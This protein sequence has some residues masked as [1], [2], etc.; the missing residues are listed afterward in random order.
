MRTI[1]LAT[2]LLCATH[3]ICAA[4]AKID[5]QGFS[6]YVDAA[7]AWVAPPPPVVAVAIK[8]HGWHYVLNDSQMQ[9]GATYSENTHI[10]RQ[11]NDTAGLQ[12]GARFEA[13]FD[14]AYQRLTFHDISVLRGD[15][16]IDVL[17]RE[18]ISLLR[19]E[20]GLERS[21]YDGKVTAS[22]VVPGA[23]VG[24]RLSYRYTVTGSNP[25]F[26]NKFVYWYPTRLSNAATDQLRFRFVYPAERQLKFSVPSGAQRTDQLIDTATRE[27]TISRRGSEKLEVDASSDPSVYLQDLLQVSEYDSW[28]DVS[29]WGSQLFTYV[30]GSD[31]EVVKLAA[32]LRTQSKHDAAS[33]TAA[34]IDF[35][36]R[37]VRYFGIFFADSSHRPNAPGLVLSRRFGDC[38]DKALL[39]IALLRELGV[40]ASPV[41]VSQFYRGAVTK[42]MPSPYAFDHVIVAAKVDGVLYWIDPTRLFGAGSLANRQAWAFRQG[43]PLDTA[44]ALAVAP[45]RPEGDLDLEATDRFTVGNL[46]EPARLR[47]EVRY[48]GEAAERVASMMTSPQRA[49]VEGVIFEFVDRLFQGR[50]EAGPVQYERNET[51]GDVLLAREYAIPNLFEIN[52]QL[53]LV[54]D[55]APWTIMGELRTNP[56]QKTDY[57]LGAQRRSR[58]RLQ[59]D[60]ADK[61]F[62]EAAKS[63]A[64]T[65]DAHFRL[66]SELTTTSTSIAANYDY[67]TLADVVPIGRW[68]A[69][70]AK[71]KEALAKAVLSLR[72]PP[73]PE[74]DRAA[75]QVALVDLGKRID[76]KDVLAV[77]SDQVRARVD[78]LLLN[79]ALEKGRLSPRNRSVALRLLAVAKDHTGRGEAALEDV[80]A[81][82]VTDPEN[83]RAFESQAE[84]EF[85]LGRFA[86]A[87]A[88]LSRQSEKQ[89]SGADGASRYLRGRNQ[90]YLGN[91][92]DARDDF[93]ESAQERTGTGKIYSL[94]WAAIAD[95]RL[96]KN[97]RQSLK[98]LG[99]VAESDAW[100]APV[101]AHFL[102]DKTE[103]EVLRLASNAKTDGTKREQLCEASFFLGQ[104]RLAEGSRS[105]AIKHFEKAIDT[106]VM[107]YIEFRASRFELARLN[108]HQ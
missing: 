23:Q 44:S 62:A 72:V 76:R 56:N 74:N 100:P 98:D 82:L 11:I 84:I 18:N 101:L 106:E 67:E 105:A 3:A 41:L 10:V 97:V 66:R 58:H 5:N 32:S 46:R 37:D 54:T 57:F 53:T 19:R 103:T 95:S 47:S 104:L 107:E 96:G 83:T 51:S 79:A 73:I 48:F 60:F 52:D 12:D 35:V 29:R 28:Q 31:A 89:G 90:F 71:T 68:P 14:P 39:T 81:A 99:A 2:A 21:Q 6:Y 38:K 43:L 33:L 45:P 42:V 1:L 91:F 8:R 94:L 49:A 30:P 86:D 55:F 27:V 4:P 50:S 22:V 87:L 34:A 77:T 59:F 61:V 85:G 25:V 9:V 75:L 64:A 20:Q 16:R 7:P 80:K 88:T 78:E 13:Q 65:S 69:Y 63:S 26:A 40:E 92:T 15:Q 17:K 108:D 102:G 24:D 70:S 93:V 36:Q